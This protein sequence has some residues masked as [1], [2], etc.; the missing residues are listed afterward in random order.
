MREVLNFVMLLICMMICFQSEAQNKVTQD[1]SEYTTDA[2]GNRH[3]VFKTFFDYW[4]NNV[5]YVGSYS[6]GIPVGVHKS[7]DSP[8]VIAM[9]TTYQNGKELE[10]KYYDNIKKFGNVIRGISKRELFNSKGDLVGIWQWHADKNQLVQTFGELPGKKGTWSQVY[11]ADVEDR[12][13]TYTEKYVG[14]DTTYIWYGY[15]TDKV[16]LYR[17]TAPNYLREYDQNGN[18]VKQNGL[19]YG[20]SSSNTHSSGISNYKK[21]VNDDRTRE[22]WDENEVHY[23]KEHYPDYGE[24]RYVYEILYQRGDGILDTYVYYTLTAKDGETIKVENYPEDNKYVLFHNGER[25]LTYYIAGIGSGQPILAHHIMVKG[26]GKAARYQPFVDM[27]LKIFPR[28]IFRKFDIKYNGQIWAMF[29]DKG[30]WVISPGYSNSIVSNESEDFK[31]I[32]SQ[33]GLDT[34]KKNRNSGYVKI[35]TNK[36]LFSI[37]NGFSNMN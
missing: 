20:D 32:V 27:A 16:Q 7:Y 35:G 21:D 22:E 29:D 3:G 33:I 26:T 28:E 12:I 30:N 11:P 14:N 2:D 36:S 24:Q 5:S 17:K 13:P 25:I 8:G 6:H 9:E 1:F 31:N 34:I 15:R 37:Q 4:H 19:D 23:V 10:R 18:I